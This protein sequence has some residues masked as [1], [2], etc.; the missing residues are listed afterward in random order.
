MSDGGLFNLFQHRRAT[1]WRN[2]AGCAAVLTVVVL[3]ACSNLQLPAAPTTV[4]PVEQKS[5]AQTF[6]LKGRISVRVNEKLD[7][8]QILWRRTPDEERIGLYSPFGSQVAELVVDKQAGVVTLRQGKDILTAASVGAL[9]Q[10]LLGAPLD[11]DR[12][13]EWVQGFGLVEN[14]GTD[15]KLTNGETWRVNA[16]RYHL[17]GDNGSYQFASKVTA[18]R[19]D[20]V[21]RLVIDEWTQ[22]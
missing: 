21:V 14:E 1:L 8:G 3:G 9:T 20:T 5:L 15:V 10:S 12:L 18:S 22:H 13:N 11:L 17:T 6:L 4:L 2:G 7:S 19:G 16:E